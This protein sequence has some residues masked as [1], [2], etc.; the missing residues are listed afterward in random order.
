MLKNWKTSLTSET[1][2]QQPKTQREW[3][4][5]WHCWLLLFAG[6]STAQLMNAMLWLQQ[7][8]NRTQWFFF[9][10]L[11]TTIRKHNKQPSWNVSKCMWN[12]KKC[13]S[14]FKI[15]SF[16]I[17]EFLFVHKLLHPEPVQWL[18]VIQAWIL[19][20]YNVWFWIFKHISNV[21]I[22]ESLNLKLTAK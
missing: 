5:L 14:D 11:A 10:S 22:K 16:S 4:N 12:S 8:L 6:F 9:I 1:A 7:W 2:S 15:L 13:S 19:Y 3:K 17:K 18:S 20:S 21:K